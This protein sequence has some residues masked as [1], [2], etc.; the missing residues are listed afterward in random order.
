M[1]KF[2]VIFGLFAVIMGIAVW[3]LVATTRFYRET[4]QLLSEVETSMEAYSEQLDDPEHIKVLEK[5]ESHWE[6]GRSLIMMFGNHSVVRNAEERIVALG[7]FTRQNELSDA[8]VSLRQAQRYIAD[9]MRDVVPD[10]INL[11]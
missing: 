10:F 1:K 5:L 2:L 9:V 4:V 8:M 7:E 3:E 6:S 11:L